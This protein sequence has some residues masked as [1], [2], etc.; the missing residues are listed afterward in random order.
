MKS[1]IGNII[2]VIPAYNEE[3]YIDEI[4]SKTNSFVDL[5]LVCDDGS[6][7]NTLKMIR[8][9]DAIFLRNPKKMCKGYSLLSLFKE[10]IKYD[11]QIIITLD[12]DGQHDPHD[13]PKFF[14][15]ILY[16]ECDFVIGSRYLPGS[17]TDISKIRNFGLRTINIL[18]NLLLGYPYSDS[19]CG[20]RAF[21]K[22][23]IDI[24]LKCNENGY[25]IET[26]QLILAMKYGLKMTE[27]PVTVRYR[28]IPNT[29]KMNYI[30][31]GFIIT[32]YVF[33]N[34]LNNSRINSKNNP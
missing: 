16:D 4:I 14:A 22:K 11:P 24:M 21:G 6:T 7:D 13:I 15:P 8:K 2:A 18:H 25:G 19:Q 5:V 27:V 17:W 9:N 1:Q 33:N 31:H 30:K 20:F 34:F 12:G 10:A 26:E 28:G 3:S 32:K 29:S 23:G